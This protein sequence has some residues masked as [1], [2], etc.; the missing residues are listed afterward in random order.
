MVLAV[1]LAPL[2]GCASQDVAPTRSTPST[3][4]TPPVNASASQ[5][6]FLGGPP[7]LLLVAP[8]S[9]SATE[10]PRHDYLPNGSPLTTWEAAASAPGWLRSFNATVW[11]KVQDPTLFDTKSCSWGL[12]VAQRSGSRNWEASLCIYETTPVKQAGVHRL[13]FKRMSFLSSEPFAPGDT[14][15]IGFFSYSSS[16][17]ANPTVFVLVNATRYPSQVTLETDGGPLLR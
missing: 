11:V 1:A 17:K 4:Q 9:T 5:R 8:T 10:I 6:I 13:D 14:L 3:S 2:A 12:T 16:T 7:A 15:E